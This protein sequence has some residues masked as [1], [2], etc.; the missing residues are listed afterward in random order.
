MLVN[1]EALDPEKFKD[2][3]ITRESKI[4]WAQINKE[5]PSWYEIPI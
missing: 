2:D 3:A 1:D 4:M 5:E